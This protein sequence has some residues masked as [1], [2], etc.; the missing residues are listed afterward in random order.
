MEEGQAHHL[1]LFDLELDGPF[2]DLRVPAPALDVA[3]ERQRRV[4]HGDDE[5]LI[6][7]SP[8]QLASLLAAVDLLPRHFGLGGILGGSHTPR[9][10][11][12]QLS[13]GI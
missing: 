6:L 10:G 11:H 9:D 8:R 5:A 12:F 3:A 2:H 7:A 1:V 4:S 13:R